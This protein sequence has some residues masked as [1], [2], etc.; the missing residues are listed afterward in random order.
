MSPRRPNLPPSGRNDRGKPAG[1]QRGLR[2]GD[3]PTKFRSV[4]RG[5]GGEQVEG[6]RAVYELLKADR[7]KVREV[8][9]AAGTDESDL[10]DEIVQL[11]ARQRVPVRH[12]PRARLDA[13]SKSDAPQGIMARAAELPEHDLAEMCQ[14][15]NGVKPFLLAF[16][17]VTDPHNLGSLIRTGECAG[18]TGI[19]LPKHRTAHVTP[20]VTK[21]SAGAVEHLPITLVPGLPNAMTDI[22][23]AGVWTVGLDPD[24]DTDIHDLNV[25]SEPLLLIF[26]AEGA[27]LSRLTK[28]RCDVLARIP[29]FGSVASLN[30]AAAGAVACF[31]VARRR[32]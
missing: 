4:E 1:P 25:A 31:E 17:G 7:R 27:G 28:Q 10:L 11:C 23:A 8:L 24:G 5:V 19:V 26:G 30:V 21:A 20:T 3:V 9:I 14:T 15:K 13:E 32:T 29:Q 6:R 16:D 12:I 2:T 18:V 22:K